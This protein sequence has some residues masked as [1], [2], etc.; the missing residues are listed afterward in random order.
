VGKKIIIILLL[1]TVLSLAAG[2]AVVTI[3]M[4]HNPQGEFC[5]EIVGNVCVYDWQA[6]L[7]LGAIWAAASFFS[8]S[9][10]WLLVWGFLKTGKLFKKKSRQNQENNG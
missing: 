6:L 9:A 5:K 8:L 3:A 1:F 7:L 2:G 10:L 4:E